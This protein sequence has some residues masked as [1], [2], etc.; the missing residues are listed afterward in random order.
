MTPAG[1]TD[2][3]ISIDSIWGGLPP[4][5]FQWANGSNS[6]SLSN[7]IRGWYSFTILDS[8]GCI[9]NN[10]VYVPQTINISVNSTY[11]N[12]TCL[13]ND[14]SLTAFGSGGT[15]PYT[16]SYSNGGTGQTLTGLQGG[17]YVYITAT[18]VNGCYGTGGRYIG[19]STPI[20][21]TYSITPTV[22]DS[23]T[24]SATLSISGGTTPYFVSWNVYPPQTGTTLSNVGEG[25]YNFQITDSTGCM[26]TGTVTI[27]GASFINGNISSV[28][29]TCP[30]D[31]GSATVNVY[32]S[33]P[34]FTYLWSNGQTTQNISNLSPDEY[35]CTVTDNIGCH[36]EFCKNII[37]TTPINIGLNITDAS[38]IFTPDGSISSIAFGGVPPYTFWT[39][40]QAGQI[41][42]NLLPGLYSSY[43]QDSNGC[44]NLKTAQVGY[45]P[46][47]D[48]CYCTISGRVF[49]D[50]NSNCTYDTGEELVNNIQIH[51]SSY[52][53]KYTDTNGVYSF[54]VPTGT[55][56]IS[57]S[58]LYYYPLATCQNNNITVNATAS[59]GCSINVDFANAIN[60]I[61]DIHLIRTFINPPIPGFEYNQRLI[62][63]NQG[64]T[65]ES[66]IQLSSSHDGQ[67]FWTNT[68]PGI[69]SQP[70]PVNYP[71]WYTI[72]SGFPVLQP[73]EYI[74]FVVNYFVPVNIPLGTTLS[75]DDT[76]AFAPPMNNW[77]TDYSPWNNVIQF[78]DIVVGSFDPN[79]KEVSP[80]GTGVQGY[81]NKTDSVL[82]YIIHFENI[83][84]YVAQNIFIIDT[85]DS[86]LEISSLTPVYS[87]HYCETEIS[88]NGVIKF[89]F[90]NIYLPDNN[91]IN[92]KGFICYSVKQ[93]PALMPGTEITN[94]AAI[95]FDF[96]EPVITNT[97]LNTIAW[98]ENVTSESL[99]QIYVYPNPADKELFILHESFNISEW[100]IIDI[101]GKM[102]TTQKI[103]QGSL[104]KINIEGL[105]SG[106]Y[107]LK[108]L[109]TEGNYISVKF[110]KK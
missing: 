108:I 89:S 86:D 75:Y 83:G 21:A 67:L 22:C 84:S 93:K 54:K 105:N 52:G 78:T 76:T 56:T 100:Y 70:D 9:L 26:R 40:G 72:S 16:Y 23:A 60:P 19:T 41:A 103:N 18:D 87:T 42:T 101:L 6:L 57:E 74:P 14:G 3:T 48:S 71:N 38:C 58:V 34:P 39:A 8:Q 30:L 47:N 61:H 80:K 88:E 73:G 104:Q 96:N 2:G 107:I 7:L 1:C 45:N 4:Y 82:D 28:N 65:T 44:T 69:Y 92:N 90:P 32:G 63:K 55:Y 106:L 110:I 20:T 25:N 37:M 79:F 35:L 94:T 85:L 53:Y 17:V 68:I 77:L 43:V 98:P 66:D 15:P 109:S 33:N 62:V 13:Q 11:S 50:Q 64:T 59:S 46:A 81:I 102:Q 24:G 29:C 36:E 27:T 91:E 5:I 12:A 31:N 97:T 99:N 10:G 49:I 95:Y 51:C